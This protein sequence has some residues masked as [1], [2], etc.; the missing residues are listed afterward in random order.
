[1]PG[2]SAADAL[3]DLLAEHLRHHDVGQQQVDRAVVLGGELERLG[4]AAGG[5]HRVAVV[6]EDPARDLEHRRLVLDD[7]DR[8]AAAARRGSR[9]SSPAASGTARVGRRAAARVNVVPRPGSE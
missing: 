8:L 3:G 6:V 4:A 2:R 9:R 1:M 7:E 5:Q